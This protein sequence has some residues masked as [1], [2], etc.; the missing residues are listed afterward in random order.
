MLIALSLSSTKTKRPEST[1]RDEVRGRFFHKL[2][3][4]I[5]HTC[6]YVT[7]QLLLQNCLLLNV[8]ELKD[9]VL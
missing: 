4:S 1:D 6:K 7:Y 9:A 5:A 8:A 2:R 3:N